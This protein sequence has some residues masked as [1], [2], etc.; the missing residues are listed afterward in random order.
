MKKCLI[1]IV[2]GIIAFVLG[3]KGVFGSVDKMFEDYVY[4]NPGNVNAKIKIIKIDDRTMNKL[5]DFS[6]WNRDVY[7]DLV[8]T[9]CVSKEVKPAVIGFDV[10]FSSEKEKKSDKRFAN[11]C[12]KYNNVVTGFSYVFTKDIVTDS[13]GNLVS[14]AMTVQEKVMPYKKLA[15]TTEQGFVN[16][17]MDNDDSVIRSSFIHFDEED[18]TRTNSFSAKIYE[19][20]MK[21]QGKKAKFPHKD[22][23]MS[24]K[25]SGTVSDY[26]NVSLCDV[27]DGTI[28]SEAFDDCIV[29]VGAYAAGMMD[30]YFVPVD[31]GQQMYGVEIHANV[32]QALMEGKT[33]DSIPSWINGLIAALVTILLIIVCEKLSV[34]KIVILCLGVA[35]GKIGIGALLFKEGYS[36]NNLVT[37]VLAI[38]IAIYYIALHYYRA[39]AAKQSIEKAFSK[40]VAPQVVSEIAKSGTYE[41]KLGGENRDVAVLFVDIRGF[42][43]LSESLEP[44]Q[45]VD[46]LN[47]YLE[48]TTSC[49]FRHGG[50]LDKFIGDA[51]MAVFNAPFDTED[52]VYRAV[53]AAWDI[54]QGGNKIEKQFVERYGKHVGFGVGVNCGPAVVGNIGCDFRMDYTAI[55]DTVNTSAR[56]EAN[57]PRGTVYISDTVYEQVKD[58]ITVEEV[59]EIPLKGKSKGV[60]V[61]SITG[62][63]NYTSPVDTFKMEDK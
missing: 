60:F 2:C 9:L 22:G 8:E 58:R 14:N 46:I 17:L 49:I 30:A 31:R 57:A 11:L 23:V 7:A 37:P 26:E 43:P 55:G 34:L 33:L 56:L 32:I 52:Y 21:Q 5:G 39:R 61:Y 12:G 24:F 6:K 29:L 36:W 50:T 48:L 35:L 3:A 53:L 41:L 1:S 4:H 15:K 18:G 42:T 45:V 63:N 54:V 59:G 19:K 62:V 40:Y 28:P 10:L 25:Y 47:S 20:Y 38:V 13:N 44:E 16:A 27:L 51:T